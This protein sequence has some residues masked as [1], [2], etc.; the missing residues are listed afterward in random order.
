MAKKAQESAPAAEE[1]KTTA[2]LKRR[3]SQRSFPAS[4]FEEPLEFAKSVFKIGSGQPIKRLTLFDQLGKSPESSASRQLII[5]SGKYGLTKGGVSA[6]NIE[7]TAEG[8]KAVDDQTPERERARIKAQLAIHNIEPFQ[9]LYQRFSGNKLPAQ[10]VLVDAAKDLGIDSNHAAEAVETFVVNLTFVGLLKT[11]S[12]AERIIPMDMLLDSITSTPATAT[13]PLPMQSTSVVTSEHA[14]Y[15]AT[16]FY[17][18]PIGD[19]ASETRKHSDLFLGTIVEPAIEQFQLKVVRADA[20][21]KPGVI[22]RQI[23]EY[24]MRSRLVI[25]D[26]SFHN[27]NV[28]YELALRHAIKLPIVQIIRASDRIPFDV[29]QMRTIPI[30][31]SDIYS[32]APKIETYRAEVANHVRRALE[33]DHVVDTPIST[34]FPN[35]V[36]TLQ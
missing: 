22:T 23:I 6:D 15:E 26:L 27:P 9:A 11:L 33:T 4:S 35:M 8:L 31:T 12:G 19:E 30:D 2:E 14:S 3:R 5:N 24:I 1:S 21:D 36:V 25:A 32:F 34:Y 7:L 28:F 20:I 29:N 18:A 13:R 17:I 16:C 10:A